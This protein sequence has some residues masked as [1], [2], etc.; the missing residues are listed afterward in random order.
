MVNYGLGFSFALPVV[1]A[2]V[3]MTLAGLVTLLSN[4]IAGVLMV[5]S[6]PFLRSSSYGVQI[7]ME[8]SKFREYG[9]MHGIR[10]G[11]WKSLDK[12]PYLNI[13]KGRD[14]M[15]MYS[16]SNQSTTVIGD[17]LEV[18]LPTQTHRTKIVIQ[19][20]DDQME[21]QVF[22]QNLAERL[23]KELVTF[24]PQRKPR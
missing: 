13:M 4:P 20:F 18:C 19:K 16:R 11:D 22:A 3:I 14:S 21:A 9:S 7:D 15:R 8:A 1:A 6:G 23:G 24:N 5:V 10:S 17:R 12:T 2:E